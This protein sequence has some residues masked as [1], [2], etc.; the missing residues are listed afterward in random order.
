MALSTVGALGLGAVAAIAFAVIGFLVTVL[1]STSER[2]GEFA[3]LRALGLSAGQLRRWLSLENAF[4]LALGM[5]GGIGLGL[6][7][8]ALV[9]PFT[10]LAADGSVP[11]PGPTTVVPVAVPLLLLVLAAGLLVLTVLIIVRQVPRIRVATVLRAGE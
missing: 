1:V 2:A 8:A 11:V 4:L 7:V 10:T 3:L 6:L 5:I 9:V